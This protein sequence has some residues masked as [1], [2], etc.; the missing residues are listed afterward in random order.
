MAVNI[1][2]LRRENQKSIEALNNSISRLRDMLDEGPP[3]HEEIAI[4]AE[5]NNAQSN[6]VHLQ[7]VRAHL[8]A[9][10][11]IV[12]PISPDVE[13]R[14]DV[15]SARLDEAILEDFVINATFDVVQKVLGAV[16]EISTLTSQ[17]T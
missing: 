7:L 12:A 14:L 11:T 3:L 4:T 17:N 16:K 1:A 10:G 15:L 8:N 6:K 13:A 5:L 2:R 9:A